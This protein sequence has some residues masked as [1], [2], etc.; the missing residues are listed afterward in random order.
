MSSFA[1]GVIAALGSA[2]AWAAALIVLK[3]LRRDLSPF[4]LSLVAALLGIVC[5]GGL[6]LLQGESLPPLTA[7]LA[8]GLSGVLG[9]AVGDTLFFAAMPLL[10]AQTLVLLGF[11]GQ[12]LTVVFGV[13][14]LGEQLN[15]QQTLGIIATLIGLSVVT[16][17]EAEESQS[18]QTTRTGLCFGVLSSLAAAGSVIL[19]KQGLD[20]VSATQ[21]TFIRLLWGGLALLVLGTTTKQ[22]RAWLE[23]LSH[24]PTLVRCSLAS[25]LAAFGGFY[26]FHYALTK[27]DVV[28]AAPLSAAEPLFTL[29]LA[30]IVLRERSGPAGLLGTALAAGG[31]IA[32]CI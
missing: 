15:L 27:I 26:L 14:L 4:G 23:P 20:S 7:S 25:L 3:T 22:L 12:G 9:I 8:L 28:V 32:I 2:A 18:A 19:A 5:I 30:L 21:G 6:S 13:L 17:D 11:L 31:I 16:L 29:P 1:L 24:R 10:R